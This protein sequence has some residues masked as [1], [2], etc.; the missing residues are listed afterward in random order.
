VNSLILAKYSTQV[1]AIVDRFIDFDR[2]FAPQQAMAELVACCI[3]STWFLEAFNVIGFLWPNGESGSGK[4]QLLTLIA[5]LS[6]LGQ[7]ILAGGSFA[8]L[9]EL[10][11]YG[12]TLCFDDAENLADKRADPDKRTLLLAGNRRGNAIT[13]KEPTGERGWQTRYINTFCPSVFGYH[14]T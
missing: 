10:A 6:Y 7:L 1:A 9:R 4:T 11:D 8:S 5:E 13:V 2:S 12:A 14:I 3:L